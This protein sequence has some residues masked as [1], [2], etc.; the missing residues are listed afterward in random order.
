MQPVD[1]ALRLGLRG[2]TRFRC[3]IA[4]LRRL[5]APVSRVDETTDLVIAVIGHEIACVGRGIAGVSDH[6]TCVGPAIALV[7]DAIALVRDA[8]AIVGRPSPLFAGRLNFGQ[9]SCR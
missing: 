9:C 7:R 3:P 8:V 6:V 4:A 5:I 2:T 1:R